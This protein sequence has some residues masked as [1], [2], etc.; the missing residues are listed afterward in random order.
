MGLISTVVFLIFVFV[1]YFP[2]WRR[3]GKTDRLPRGTIAVSILLG[4]IP[5]FILII[6]L[7][8]PI[9]YL[10][11][12]L[13]ASRTAFL[14]SDAYISAALTEECVKFL[15][16][17]LVIRKVKPK[18]KVDFALILGAV[19][20]GY[21]VTESLLGLG[22]SVLGSVFRGVFAMHIIWQ[23]WM[24]LYYYEY[25]QAKLSG[26]GEG[27]RKNF[28]L[29]FLVPVLLHGTNDFLV[30]MA[31]DSF[32]ALD[33]EAL[34]QGLPGEAVAAVVWLV[35]LGLFMAGALVYQIITFKKALKAAKESRERDELSDGEET[36][37]AEETS[38]PEAKEEVPQKE[39]A[40]A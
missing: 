15:F 11:K 19:G 30:F 13:F 22:G 9:G 32:K 18:R 24:G 2:I 12:A 31:E 21:E 4:L 27:R 39:D 23:L 36:A 35:I 26:D 14:A 29:A 3:Q 25:R 37:P 38:A 7:Q 16:A 40:K 8:I 28:L 34:E 17:Y 10:E 5:A 6:A 1:W 20:L 33:F